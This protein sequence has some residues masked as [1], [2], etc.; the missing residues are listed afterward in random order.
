M[1]RLSVVSAHTSPLE[2][3]STGDAGGMNVYLA[4]VLP[5]LAVLGWEV[6]VL[7]RGSGTLPLAPGVEVVGVPVPEG[8]KYALAAAAPVFAHAA[9]GADVVHSHYWVSGLAGMLTG[10]P[11]V[12]SMHS[13][14]LAKNVRLVPGDA[15][16]P[17]ERIRSEHSVLASA[18]A[19]V[20]AGTAEY[21]DVVRGYGVDAGKV[22][23]V[24]PGV[25][26]RF[27]PGTAERP[28]EIV[29]VGRMQPLKGQLLAV[30]ALARI[31]AGERPV[32]RLVGGPAP[33]REGYLD[34]VAEAVRTLGVAD[35]VR[36]DGVA[37]RD[38]T[39]VRLRSARLALVPSAAETF[40][41]IALEAAASGTPVLA[42][43]TT[44]LVDAV[45]EGRSG[46][47]IDSD[48]PGVWAAE[49]RR[50]L[51]DSVERERLGRGGVEWAAAHSWASTAARLDAVY[52]GL[53]AG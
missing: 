32:L 34:Q 44:G 20:V 52:R 45:S 49:I 40:G 51:A 29:L 4:A 25:D 15:R 50:L 38:E 48:D 6:T 10:A 39:A 12:H 36:F 35:S 33:G 53:L 5:E 23:I 7:T 41:L 24:A 11:H 8:D 14:S 46:V 31:P 28:R 21:D 13:N 42:R 3:P 22:T 30:Q 18:D 37:D 43:R 16:E 47:L 27:R 9:A 1:P 2:Q 17:E 19:V 26:P